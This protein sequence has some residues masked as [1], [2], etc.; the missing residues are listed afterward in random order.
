MKK[1]I[2]ITGH[3]GFIGSA[4][5]K[6]IRKNKNIEAI[7][8]SRSEGIDLLNF[9]SMIDLSNID[10]IIHIAGSSGVLKSWCQPYDIYR[11]NILSTLNVLEHARVHRKKPVIYISSYI[12]GIPKY[13]PV[14]EKH[15]INCSNP[16][17]SSKRQA[18]MLCESYSKD[19]DIPITILRPFN[20]YGPGQSEESLIARLIK[21]VKKKNTIEVKD[22]RPKRDYLY[23]DDL[24]DAIIK[25]I[26]GEKNHENLN[27]YNL[28]FGQSY[29]VKNIIDIV[30]KITNKKL[31]V[32]CDMKYRPNE[33]MDCFSNSQK[34]SKRFSWKPNINI[35]QGIFNLLREEL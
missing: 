20:I 22:L 3:T 30:A 28:G 10:K 11:N 27:I 23:I 34:F 32:H 17:A 5:I 19:F 21:Q 16:Y 29:S 26:F 7:G 6:A 4:L 24:I 13:L 25:V 2:A 15:P 14:D 33:I 1:R 31:S 12:Y 9:E 8:I 18:E 35:V